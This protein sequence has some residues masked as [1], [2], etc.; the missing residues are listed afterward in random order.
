MFVVSLTSAVLKEH[1]SK[2]ISRVHQFWVGLESR[3]VEDGMVSFVYDGRKENWLFLQIVTKL[4]LIHVTFNVLISRSISS[5]DQKSG[6]AF[7]VPLLQQKLLSQLLF[8][9]ANFA[10]G[11]YSFFFKYKP[12][13]KWTIEMFTKFSK[14]TIRLFICHLS[15]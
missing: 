12:C 7:F 9:M 14:Q 4:W 11:F 15:S 13:F 3:P 10:G 5:K 1:W 2:W 8:W 6:N